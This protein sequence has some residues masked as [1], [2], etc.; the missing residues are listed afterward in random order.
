MGLDSWGTNSLVARPLLISNRGTLGLVTIQTS[1][2]RVGICPNAGL[3]TLPSK[4]FKSGSSPSMVNFICLMTSWRGSWC[5]NQLMF[6][7]G[8][9]GTLQVP[10]WKDNIAA[11]CYIVVR[12]HSAS[13]GYVRSISRFK[14]LATWRKFILAKVQLL[15][16]TCCNSCAVRCRCQAS[17]QLWPHLKTWS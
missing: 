15:G 2:K 17:L 7:A 12:S 13:I 14:P 4:T 6:R 8:D 9:P 10:S 3:A 11:Y 5:F 1:Q 16:W